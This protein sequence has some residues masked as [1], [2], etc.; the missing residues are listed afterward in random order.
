MEVICVAVG[1]NQNLVV[2]KLPGGKLQ[3]DLMNLPWCQVSVL[4]EGLDELKEL[5][6]V[7]FPILLLGGHHFEIGGIGAAVKPGYQAL[8][9]VGGFPF[10]D[11]V[12]H[13]SQQRSFGLLLIFDRGK[14]S[15]HST[16]VSL[17][18]SLWMF[19]KVSSNSSSLTACTFPILQRI[20]S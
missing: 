14:G 17:R 11:G 12:E 7:R 2:G 5:L 8:A 18:S 19:A 4:G 6:L 1:G 10:V 3:A 20:T 9:L 13:G 15:H 16:S